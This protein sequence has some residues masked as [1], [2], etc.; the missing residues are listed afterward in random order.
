ME[1]NI[2][3]NPLKYPNVKCGK[4]GCEVWNQGVILKKIPGLELGSGTEDQFVDLPVFYCSNCGEILPEYRKIYKM[5]GSLNEPKP[6]VA[7]KLIV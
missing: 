3:V 2:R 1:N 4:C 7:P 5:D 6:E